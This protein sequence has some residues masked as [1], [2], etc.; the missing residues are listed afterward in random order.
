[1]RADLGN[2]LRLCALICPHLRPLAPSPHRRPSPQ[3]YCSL[4]DAYGRAHDIEKAE[5]VFK[6]MT[7]RYLAHKDPL[8]VRKT[9]AG[10]P[11][12]S[13]VPSAESPRM[14]DSSSVRE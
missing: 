12:T 13:G 5:N 7:R 6:E 10:C 8:V 9:A 2:M 11:Y 4:V 3:S 14:S 1:M